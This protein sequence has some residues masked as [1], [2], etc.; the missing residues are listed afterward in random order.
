[1][2]TLKNITVTVK[3]KRFTFSSVP[4]YHAIKTYNV[5]AVK[6]HTF[7]HFGIKCR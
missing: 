3:L 7:L 5:I 4:R 1:V 6:L 2:D